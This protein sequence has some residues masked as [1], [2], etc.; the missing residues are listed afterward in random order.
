MPS[1]GTMSTKRKAEAFTGSIEDHPEVGDGKLYKFLKSDIVL[2]G[3]RKHTTVALE[4]MEDN[5]QFTMNYDTFCR[6]ARPTDKLVCKLDVI[7]SGEFTLV[8][9]EDGQLGQGSHKKIELVRTRDGHRFT[10]NCGNFCR[11]GARPWEKLVYQLD[12]IR[13]GE[14]SLVNNEDGQLGQGAGKKIRLVRTR[15][16]H[17]FTMSCGKFCMRGNRPPD[18]LVYQL[19]VIGSGEFTL[20]K[21]EDGQLGQGSN[22]KIELIR[23]RDGHQFIMLCKSFCQGVRPP[24][25]LVYQL[26][27]IKSGW[28]T[29]VHKDDGNLGQSSMKR[30]NLVRT[31]DQKPMTVHCATFCRGI[32][33]HCL[34]M[35]TP[36]TYAPNTCASCWCIKFPGA[37]LAVSRNA[38]NKTEILVAAMLEAH[39]GRVRKEHPT[40]DKKREDVVL[41]ST[42]LA[43]AIDGIHHFNDHQYTVN[44]SIKPCAV[45]QQTDTNKTRWWLEGHPGSS[46]VRF[47]QD[48]GWIGYPVNLL[49]PISFDFVNATNYINQRPELYGGKV[50]FL[51]KMDKKSYYMEHRRLLDVE[52]I[53]H[54]TL[55]PRTIDYGPYRIVED[56]RFILSK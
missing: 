38:G 43:V 18:K 19:E 11:L 22:K 41:L 3:K 14:F 16:G 23:T 8:H 52:G 34:A 29:L 45:T 28:F 26:H 44:E 24:D 35:M 32:C 30:I 1:L 56:K 47:K 15:D 10:V 21:N 36:C 46:Y 31:H 9:D 25:K 6:G 17:K 37:S 39:L 5:H 12:V 55:D 51:E 7:C 2:W 49:K 50:V 53:G 33:F 54:V 13:S 42:N 20:V 40:R 27:A 48:D 4:R